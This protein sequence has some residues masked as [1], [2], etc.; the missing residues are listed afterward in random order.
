M[1]HNRFIFYGEG[2]LA[3]PKLEDQPLSFV[4][5]GYSIIRN[6]PEYEYE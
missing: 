6:Y 5:S 2:L 1:F 3:Q 4:R